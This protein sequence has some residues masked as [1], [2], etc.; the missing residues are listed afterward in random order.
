MSRRLVLTPA[1]GLFTGLWVVS[2]GAA[3]VYLTG[4]HNSAAQAASACS[5]KAATS[6]HAAAAPAAVHA[7]SAARSV[8]RPTAGRT[9]TA[10]TLTGAQIIAAHTPAAERSTAH[11]KATHAGAVHTS[12]AAQIITAH[13]LAVEVRSWRS[14]SR[15]R[16]AQAA[17]LPVL[18]DAAARRVSTSHAAQRGISDAAQA[19]ATQTSSPATPPAV[20]PDPSPG[21]GNVTPSPSAGTPS[22]SSASNTTPAKHSQPSPP[23]S[24]GGGN[25]TPSASPTP[26]PTPTP[27]HTTTPPPAATLCVSLQTL[28]GSNS[29]KPGHTV[30]YAI[31]VWL[32]SGNGGTAKIGLNASPSR[33]KPAFSVC[34]PTGG[35]S[36]SVS[37]LKA[38]QHVEMQ[39][40]LTAAKDLAGRHIT[41]TVTATSHQA[42]NT[43]T[44]TDKVTVKS[45]S[46]HSSASPDRT[47]GNAGNGGTLPAASL[48]GGTSY[49]GESNPTGNLGSAFPQVSPSP[50]VSPT[51][52]QSQHQHQ[53][54]VEVTDLSAGLPLDVRLIGG[55]VIGLAI[56]AAAVTIAVARLSLRK[57]PSRH[58]DDGAGS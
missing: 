35:T 39:A 47:S 19:S 2:F 58:S 26:T 22:P 49:P 52:S 10:H 36:C 42:S 11:P 40:K 32:T 34:E 43:A 3:S 27:T 25:V 12:I 7:P 57:Q 28:G 45:K 37:G 13:A 31:F 21:G 1:I 56:L 33:V 5:A 54:Q 41:L 15:V 29:V 8:E 55:Q 18:L 48:P 23:V 16:A 38:G 17:H 53:H 50:G 51:P 14:D 6:A 24:P 44:A 9:S 20:T 4:A 46:K 30:H